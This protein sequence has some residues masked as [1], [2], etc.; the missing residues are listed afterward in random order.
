[1]LVVLVPRDGV[2]LEEHG[3]G[4]RLGALRQR[5]HGRGH[6]AL[7][8][9]GWVFRCVDV[10]GVPRGMRL[11]TQLG[12]CSC[13]RLGGESGCRCRLRWS[14]VIPLRAYCPAFNGLGAEE[15][16]QL[17]CGSAGLVPL[18]DASSTAVESSPLWTAASFLDL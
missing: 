10:D 7:R 5:A 17:C 1:M 15:W 14:T 11:A 3:R 13:P 12:C 18:R 9:G 8:A 6:C 4:A 2:V 16:L